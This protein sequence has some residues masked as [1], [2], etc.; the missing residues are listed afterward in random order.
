MMYDVIG[1]DSALAL[2]TA[3]GV[4]KY[5]DIPEWGFWATHLLEKLEED[6]APDE[7]LFQEALTDVI[8]RCHVR[9]NEG[10]WR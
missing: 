9:I 4:I 8:I 1:Q 3:A 10:K 6:Q 2:E 7:D 5:T